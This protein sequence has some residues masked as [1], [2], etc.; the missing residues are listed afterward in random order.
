MV[1]CHTV[2][3][4]SIL[5]NVILLQLAVIY[6][7]MIQRRR[8]ALKLS[9]RNIRLLTCDFMLFSTIHPAACHMQIAAV[10]LHSD[11]ELS[12]AHESQVMT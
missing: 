10:C 2:K 11:S 4:K 8:F 12:S 3:E 1:I 7:K 6:Y 5:E 9:L